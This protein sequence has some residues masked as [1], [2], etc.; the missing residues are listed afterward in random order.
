MIIVVPIVP[1]LKHLSTQTSLKF[2]LIV[3]LITWDQCPFF[4]I[5]INCGSERRAKEGFS[6]GWVSQHSKEKHLH[7]D[8][9]VPVPEYMWS[10]PWWIFVYTPL[11]LWRPRPK[12]SGESWFIRDLCYS[13]LG[14]LPVCLSAAW[15]QVHPSVFYWAVWFHRWYSC[16]IR[17]HV[18][19]SLHPSPVVQGKCKWT[20]YQLVLVASTVCT[21]VEVL[22]VNMI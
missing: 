14:N 18:L 10:T 6:T 7:P 20:I 11:I 5:S 4:M 22:K 15:P 17:A 19:R 1:G 13:H 8:W 3:W 21:H 12:C 9:D 2:W 16:K